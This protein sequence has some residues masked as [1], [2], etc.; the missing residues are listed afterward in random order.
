[1][2][3][4]WYWMPDVFEKY[5]K[6]FGKDINDYFKLKRLDPS[7]R[8]YFSED[9]IIDIPSNY[10]SLKEL[11]ESLEEGS[12]EKLDLFLKQAEKKIQDWHK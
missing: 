10:E 4:S 2:G 8:V 3:P 12:G 9:Q 11:F 6:D 1:M 7:Y 5:F